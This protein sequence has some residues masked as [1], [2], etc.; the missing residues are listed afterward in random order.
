MFGIAGK[1]INRLRQLRQRQ[2]EKVTLAPLYAPNPADTDL[3][4]H[5]TEA[6]NWLKRAQ[7]S[8]SDRGVSYGTSFGEDFDVSYPETTGYI[9][10]LAPKLPPFRWAFLA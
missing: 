3:E 5:L 10:R 9:C 8:G 1:A 2:L 6:M 4:R 7:D